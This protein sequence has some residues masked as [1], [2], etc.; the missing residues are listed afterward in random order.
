[1]KRLLRQFGMLVGLLAAFSLTT[2]TVGV[3][4]LDADAQSST[5][6]TIVDFAF[7][8][9]SLEVTAGTTVTWT[10]SGAAPHTVTADDGAFDS[11]TLQ[12][13]STFSFTFDTPGTF[14]YHCE[15]HP[16]MTATIIVTQGAVTQSA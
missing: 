11:G 8:P 10:N 14:A 15:I 4:V 2:L 5:A 1:M 16:N 12:P 9:A 7:Q 3:G 13:G 6:V